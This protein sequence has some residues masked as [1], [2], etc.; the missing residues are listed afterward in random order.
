[1]CFWQMFAL[2][3]LSYNNEATMWRK[4]CYPTVAGN[5]WLLRVSLL[6]G[7]RGSDKRQSVVHI[8]YPKV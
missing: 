7:E 4:F 3:V 1:M 2:G 8:I 6:N 5:T